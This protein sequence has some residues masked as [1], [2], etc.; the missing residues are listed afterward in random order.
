MKIT[1]L[2]LTARLCKNCMKLHRTAKSGETARSL[3]RNLVSYK[4]KLPKNCLQ[5]LFYYPS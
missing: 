3:S 2:I 1:D 4:G 5:I